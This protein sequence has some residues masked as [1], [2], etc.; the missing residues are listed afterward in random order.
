MNNEYI[1]VSKTAIQKKIEELEVF[2]KHN[3]EVAE[4]DSEGVTASELKE[5]LSQSTPLIPEIEKAF[6]SQTEVKKYTTFRAMLSGH[7]KNK[8]NYKYYKV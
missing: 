6:E 5:I 3:A 2:S 1:I 4:Y 8:T 7:L